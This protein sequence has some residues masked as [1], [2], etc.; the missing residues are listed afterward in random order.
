MAGKTVKLIIGIILLIAGVFL[1]L[2]NTPLYWLAIALG[3]LGLI[4]IIL[5]LAAKR[6]LP[7]V[8][9]QPTPPAETEPT[10]VEPAPETT[11]PAPETTE[12]APE[13][14]QEEIKPEVGPTAAPVP[15]TT[16]DP[17]LQPEAGPPPAEAPE[18]QVEEPKP[19][20]PASPV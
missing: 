1:Y 5:A 17:Q 6:Q 19:E 9:S 8:V 4:F 16:S 11:E 7:S 13:P 10:A 3:A 2:F 12:P 14:P 20:E 18:L 15:E